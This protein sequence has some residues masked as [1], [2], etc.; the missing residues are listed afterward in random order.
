MAPQS[1]KDRGFFSVLDNP[2]QDLSVQETHDVRS[3]IKWVTLSKIPSVTHAAQT[4]SESCSCH[5]NNRVLALYHLPVIHDMWQIIGIVISDSAGQYNI[6]FYKTF[7]N[8]KWI[9]F[10]LNWEILSWGLDIPSS[11]SLASSARDCSLRWNI[12]SHCVIP[13]Y[14]RYA[15]RKTSVSESVF[16]NLTIKM[17]R[18]EQSVTECEGDTLVGSDPCK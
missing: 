9:H 11:A 5:D 12:A 17:Q 13:R 15:C 1:S 8:T 6:V 16:K 4:F 14:F 7:N 18:S 3:L 10:Y 2:L